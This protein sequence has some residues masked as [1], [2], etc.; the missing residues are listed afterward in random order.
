VETYV[1]PTRPRP[2]VLACLAVVACA[3]PA[4]ASF[5]LMQIEQVVGGVCGDPTSQAIQLRQRTVGQNLVAG[6]RLVARDA[7]GVNPVI[8]LTF[9]SNVANGATGATILATTS[10]LASTFGVTPDFTLAQAIPES[11]LAA[12]RLTFEDGGGFIYWSLAWGGA[13]YT[14]S[15]AG[16]F[17]NDADGN[18]GTPFGSALPRSTSTSV[19]FPGA[20][21]APSTN[22]A[23]DYAFSSGAATLTNN[24]G[25]A[26]TLPCVFG[27]G[28]ASGDFSAWSGTLGLELCNGGD[29][30][31][32]AE[33]DEDFPLGSSCELPDGSIGAFDCAPDQRGVICS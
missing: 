12:G 1:M 25:G 9:P 28:F 33:V 4:S 23:A 5:H 21:T 15:N 27:D 11:Y 31:G 10:G 7:A 22:N 19:R 20:A 2:L 16:T 8:L 13:S 26:T 29:D 17:D 3:A 32:D 14:G 30:D 24:A 18:F 6:T